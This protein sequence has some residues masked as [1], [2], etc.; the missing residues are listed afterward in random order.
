MAKNVKAEVDL[1]TEEKIKEAARKVFTQKGYAATR[2]RDIAE[3]AGLNLALLNYYFRSKEKLFEIIMVEKMNQFF[4]VMDPIL[5]NADSKLE[6]KVEA[7]A[8]NYIDLLTKNPDLP[9]FVLSGIRNGPKHLVQIMGKADKLIKS[10]LVKQIQEKT[11]GRNP[12]HF[13]FNIL[14]LCVYPFIMNPILQSM[15]AMNDKT[16][17]QMMKERKT[18]IPEW[19]KAMLEVT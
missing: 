2:T 1:S 10:V 4:G 5:N 13:L 12:M 6:D 3:E 19:I 7:I 8:L 11:P 15:S 9:L 16:F 14:G 17:A 18:L